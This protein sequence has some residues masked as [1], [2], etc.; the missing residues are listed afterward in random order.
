MVVDG[1]V[2]RGGGHPAMMPDGA[3]LRGYAVIPGFL[4]AKEVAT[5][6]DVTFRTVPEPGRCDADRELTPYRAGIEMG[7]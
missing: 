4:T 7:E 1:R 3:R 2:D 6:R 5:A